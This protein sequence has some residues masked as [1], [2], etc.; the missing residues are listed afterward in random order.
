VT[1]DRSTVSR[2]GTARALVLIAAA[3][4]FG[5]SVLAFLV[6][7]FLGPS[8]PAGTGS[9]MVAGSVFCVIV[10]VTAITASV[11]AVLAKTTRAVLVRGFGLLLAGVMAGLGATLVLIANSS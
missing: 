10:L 7:V 2:L 4:A 11:L 6:I 9:G 1:E 8:F 5:L 3:L